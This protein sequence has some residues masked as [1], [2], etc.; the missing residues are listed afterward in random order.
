MHPESPPPT[1]GRVREGEAAFRRSTIF[2]RFPHLDPSP[3]RGRRDRLS[4]FKRDGPPHASE[5][6]GIFFWGSCL[7]LTPS[8]IFSAER[9]CS[10]AVEHRLP[11]PR[12]AGSNPVARSSPLRTSINYPRHPQGPAQPF[13][14]AT[15]AL[16]TQVFVVR[17]LKSAMYLCAE[18]LRGF[19]AVLLSGFGRER[20]FS[21]VIANGPG[22]HPRH[23]T[24]TTT[25]KLAT[26]DGA[27]GK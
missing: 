25:T 17:G 7:F 10:S 26:G 11:K 12:V 13:R 1:W 9:G 18:F 23:L 2:A 20:L 15:S 6:R 27:C 21:V 24:K 14:C 3:C 8:P 5:G 16:T 4:F 19:I 22:H